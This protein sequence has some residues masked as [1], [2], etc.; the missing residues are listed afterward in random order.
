MLLPVE[1]RPLPPRAAGERVQRL[2]ANSMM[3]DAHVTTTAVHTAERQQPRVS[4]ALHMDWL[5]VGRKFPVAAK[6]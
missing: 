5:A 2:S 6:R 4:F 3:S 1:V